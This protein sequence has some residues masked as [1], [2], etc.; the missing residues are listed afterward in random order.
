M[1][2]RGIHLPPRSAWNSNGRKYVGS[3]SN[4][5]LHAE[6]RE[7]EIPPAD[8]EATLAFALPFADATWVLPSLSS[9]PRGFP[10]SRA[11]KDVASQVRR[12]STSREDSRD[13]NSFARHSPDVD[14]TTP[15]TASIQADDETSGD[16][17][18]CDERDDRPRQWTLDSAISL[19][20]GGSASVQFVTCFQ[21][22]VGRFA[23]YVI[24]LRTTLA[25]SSKGKGERR[26]RI[27]PGMPEEVR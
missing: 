12:R 8:T 24:T 26:A 2:D 4:G 17:S 9:S 21:P 19:A 22:S 16:S 23:G 5:V 27:S 25:P 7:R 20:R 13:W 14:V 1:A 3:K 6:I 18:R 11:I 10:R 15:D